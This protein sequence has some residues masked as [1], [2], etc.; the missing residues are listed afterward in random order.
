M[1]TRIWKSRGIIGEWFDDTLQILITHIHSNTP[2]P[3]T[4]NTPPTPPHTHW[5]HTPHTHH[6]QNHSRSQLFQGQ[7]VDYSPLY[8]SPENSISLRPP[9]V[10]KCFLFSPSVRNKSIYP[11]RH[12][13]LHLQMRSDSIAWPLPQTETPEGSCAGPPCQM[14]A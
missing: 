2:H 14:S 7:L 6:T 1:L 3:H 10:P 4:E 12:W 9:I 8:P 13:P 5:K 11:T